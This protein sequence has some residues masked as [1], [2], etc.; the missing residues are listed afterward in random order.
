MGDSKK[1]EGEEPTVRISFKDN[2][3]AKEY[4]FQRPIKM[5]TLA[6]VF[7]ISGNTTLVDISSNQT[8][9]ADEKGFF[10]IP[11]TVKKLQLINQSQKIKV[12]KKREAEEKGDD[13]VQ[14]DK[15]NK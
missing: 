15:Q 9:Y 12:E 3:Q 14:E 2:E 11:L 8:F 1:A 13:L 4:R 10:D 5:R 6:K 7:S